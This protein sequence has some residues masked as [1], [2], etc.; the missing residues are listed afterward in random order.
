M[1]PHCPT[2]GQWGVI[3]NGEQEG[4]C[5]ISPKSAKRF[6]WLVNALALQQLLK[7]NYCIVRS[8]KPEKPVCR[9]VRPLLHYV[10]P[11]QRSLDIGAT[12]IGAQ[13]YFRS[14]VPKRYGKKPMP[15]YGRMMTKN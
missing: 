6:T 5:L 11:N 4:Q 10:F 2:E 8:L 9:F 15:L 3:H 12:V 13:L 7:Q 1:Y 14:G